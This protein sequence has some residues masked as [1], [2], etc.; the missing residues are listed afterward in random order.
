MKQISASLILVTL[1]S[2]V[3]SAEDE[4]S[5][6]YAGHTFSVGATLCECP[7]LQAENLNWTGEKARI[8]NRRLVCNGQAAWEDSKQMCIDT[9]MGASTLETFN[10][11]MDQYCPRIS[12]GPSERKPTSSETAQSM[13][14]APKATAIVAI[15]AIC[16]RYRVEAAC[17]AVVDAIDSSAPSNE[18]K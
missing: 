16:R 14:A 12:S 5:C 13:S 11:W 17:K 8:S 18:A 1:L 9:T 3:A 7:S 15:N 4:K 10:R 6:V 2:S